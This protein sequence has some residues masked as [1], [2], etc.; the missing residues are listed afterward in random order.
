MHT[1][2]DFGA[3]HRAALIASTR[4]AV[5]ANTHLS[6]ELESKRQAAI[7]W[8]GPRWLLHADNAPKR[9][10]APYGALRPIR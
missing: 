9:R 5:A 2:P 8:L 10:R 6:N 7:A 1:Q 4:T 3:S